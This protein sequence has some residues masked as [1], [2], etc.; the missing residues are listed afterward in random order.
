ME[1][2][3]LHTVDLSFDEIL[4]HT[5]AL[6]LIDIIIKSLQVGGKHA[7][8]EVFMW[9]FGSQLVYNKNL[10]WVHREHARPNYCKI[11]SLI[12]NYMTNIC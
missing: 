9:N 5:K 12:V 4:H 11:S 7:H 8:E 3:A 1:K 6:C 10:H 2:V